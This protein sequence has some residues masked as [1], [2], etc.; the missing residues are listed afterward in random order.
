MRSASFLLLL[1]LVGYVRA[2]EID[3]L[4]KAEMKASN[5][6]GLALAVVK[7]GKV[8][9]I[10]V[11]GVANVETGSPV[12]PETVF[13]VASMSKQFCSAA[14]LLLVQDGKWKLDDPIS[15]FVDKAPEAWSKVTIRHL[16]T[17]TG[18]I[19]ALQESDGFNFRANPSPDQ[20]IGMLAKKPLAFVPGEKF[21]YS[22]EGYSLLG[23][24]VGKVSGKPFAEFVQERLLK[25][26]GM[27]STGYYRLESLVPNRASGYIWDKDHHNN[28]I[29]L[30][31]YVMA[32]S[33]GL[34]SSLLDWVKWDAV[35][36]KESPLSKVIRDQVWTS[37]KLN[38]GKDTDYG[39]GWALS[40]RQGKAVVSHSGGTAGFSSQYI[41]QADGK[42][43]VIIF[44]NV[45][46]GGAIK[47]G[48]AIYDWYRK[49]G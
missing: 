21:E 30:R 18:G 15:Q 7:D 6:P 11:Y 26:V 17:H 3:D 22:N 23:V 27:D 41:R 24:L 32:G 45:Q 44:E 4:A 35:L 37:G 13:R 39:F 2:D 49:Q 10:G 14:T 19:P 36:G 46:G 38:D 25:P 8:V 33:G 9:K 1:T 28:A 47:L 20:Y 43:T 5:A 31:P 12:K 16:L 29:P 48:N 34:H 40:Q 42:L